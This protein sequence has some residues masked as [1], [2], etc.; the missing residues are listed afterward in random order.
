MLQA[1]RE[2]EEREEVA[3]AIREH[4]LQYADLEP[5]WE[6]EEDDAVHPSSMGNATAPPSAPESSFFDELNK[7]GEA[8]ATALMFSMSSSFCIQTCGPLHPNR[9]H[10]DLFCNDAH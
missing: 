1:K 5:D 8:A 3:R 10:A 4:N 2:K 7:V 6:S 9:P